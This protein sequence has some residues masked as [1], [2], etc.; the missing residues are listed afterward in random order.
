MKKI[1][2]S[3]LMLVTFTAFAQTPAK[4]GHAQKT[5][6][7]RATFM[8]S[9]LEKSLGLSADQKTKVYDLALTREKK[10][11]QLRTEN[12][13]KDR[14]DWADQRKQTADEFNSGMQKVLTPDQYTKWT[15]QK[16]EHQKKREAHYPQSNK[17]PEQRADSLTSH[18]EK[19]LQLTADQKTKVHDLVLTREK[20][21][22]Q[23]REKYKG[24]DPCASATE[25][26]QVRDTFDNGMK[27]ALTPEQYQK[28]QDQKKQRMEEHKKKMQ[29]AHQQHK[30]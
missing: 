12:K 15:Q 23:L 13:G 3:L 29:G 19:N 27:T 16:E 24:Q 17:T 20:A 10:I 8:A 2:A 28:W 9:H 4:T 1:I 22:D 21:N 26:K 7:E 6:E 30:K 5:P 25:R 11:D 18:L 14:C